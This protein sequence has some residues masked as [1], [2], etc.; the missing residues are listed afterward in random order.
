MKIS[1]PLVVGGIATLLWWKFV[2]S[3]AAQPLP[4]S[5]LVND[6]RNADGAEKVDRAAT[7]A[8]VASEAATVAGWGR[9]AGD[10]VRMVNGWKR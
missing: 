10:Y 6:L 8:K 2:A 1:A 7:E 4:T 3:K 9:Y 5:T